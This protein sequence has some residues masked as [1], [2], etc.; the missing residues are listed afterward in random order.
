MTRDEIVQ[1][2]HAPEADLAAYSQPKNNLYMMIFSEVFNYIVILKQRLQYFERK[3]EIL[4][5]EF[6]QAFRDGELAKF[7]GMNEYHD[8]FLEWAALCQTRQKLGRKCGDLYPR[9]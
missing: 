5:S 7:D 1:D 4:S 3:Y 6:Y 9:A 8:K 2:I